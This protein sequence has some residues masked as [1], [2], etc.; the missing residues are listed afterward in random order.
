MLTFIKEKTDLKYVGKFYY[1]STFKKNNI[2]TYSKP[3]YIRIFKKI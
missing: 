2:R 1:I 3:R